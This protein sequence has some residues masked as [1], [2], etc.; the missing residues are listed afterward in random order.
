MG[1]GNSVQNERFLSQIGWTVE[2]MYSPVKQQN[3]MATFLLHFEAI[4]P[5][6]C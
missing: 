6:T 2:A 3:K 5:L 4:S 1:A